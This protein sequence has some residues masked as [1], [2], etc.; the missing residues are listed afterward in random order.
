MTLANPL[1]PPES[2]SD[3][4]PLTVVPDRRTRVELARALLTDC[5]AGPQAR[6]EYP[7]LAE[8]LG[9]NWL[10]GQGLA[11]LVWHNW[12]GQGVSGVSAEF[13][14]H[15]RAAYYVAMG[16]DHMRRHELQAVLEAFNQHGL[17]VVAF[18]GA[19][20]AHTVYPDSACRG[21]GDFDFWFLPYQMSLAQ[22]VMEDLGYQP[23]FSPTRPLALAL[24][25]GGELQYYASS[26]AQSLVELHWGVFPGEWVQHTGNIAESAIW[27]RAQLASL[28]GQ[29]ARILDPADSLIQICV[30][31]AISH[32]FSVPWLR[33]LADVTLLVRHQPLDW[34]VIVARARD[35]RV[36]TA[37]WLVLSLTVDLA[38]LEEA[39]EPVRQLQPSA[40]RRRAIHH[41]ANAE[42]MVAMSDLSKSKW[43]YVYLLLMVDR[44]RDMLKLVRRA[45]WPER[46]WLI[47]RYDRYTI[48][49][50]LRHFF[51]AARGKI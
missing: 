47:A 51:N 23:R 12:R 1:N 43:R 36:A 48:S 49:L 35:W 17:D 41:F 40:L 25:N 50:R 46:K 4:S 11:T 14:R 38:G 20:L 34:P 29:P 24:Q 28:A 8:R 42:T 27:A 19:A 45:L 6:L 5:L 26:P 22:T 10:F 37:V 39:A 3:L 32:N 30:H 21:M 44:K 9:L 18:K 7:L 13:T 16:D 33:T 2:A 15:N 31:Y